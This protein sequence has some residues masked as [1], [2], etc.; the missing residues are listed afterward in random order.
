MGLFDKKL[1]YEGSKLSE[2]QAN[3]TDSLLVDLI[4]GKLK[5]AQSLKNP[6]P[7]CMRY[8][9]MDAQGIRDAFLNFLTHDDLNFTIS[10]M[11][12]S[13]ELEE[14]NTS[15]TIDA[16]IKKADVITERLTYVTYLKMMG[17]IFMGGIRSLV[18]TTVA[19]VRIGTVCTPLDSAV[20]AYDAFWR[21]LEQTI[22]DGTPSDVGE[23]NIEIPKL[24]L[25]KDGAKQGGQLK[26]T[27]HAYVGPVDVVPN[28]DTTDFE[29][30]FTTIKLYNDKIPEN[31]KDFL[32]FLLQLQ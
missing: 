16:N 3:P 27:G 7:E 2:L 22:E 15:D 11:K 10:E 8:H 21:K 26:A 31:L 9:V 29:G 28:S 6:D 32:Y 17:D 4:V 19:G 20:K 30:D 24:Q 1:K 13:I 14:F 12:A 5:A 23:G 25:R 18:D